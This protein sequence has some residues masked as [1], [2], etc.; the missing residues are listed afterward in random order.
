MCLTN[1]ELEELPEAVRYGKISVKD[2]LGKLA[3]GLV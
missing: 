2:A 3:E 1:E